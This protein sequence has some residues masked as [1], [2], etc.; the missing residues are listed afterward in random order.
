MQAEQTTERRKRSL[1]PVLV[2]LIVTGGV[3]VIVN[4]SFSGGVY[5][6]PL[7]DL[8]RDAPALVGKQVRVSGK[9]A[10]G[11][12]RGNV[13]DLDVTFAIEDG[14]GHTMAVHTRKILPD[15]FAE[16]RDVIVEGTLVQA[17][18]IEASTITVKCPSRYQDGE[19]TEEQA[20]AY[21]RQRRSQAAR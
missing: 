5:E 2:A 1:F 15:P 14:T 11:S 19:M 8:V 16:G 9:V 21:Y 7:G 18:R 20:R 17:D 4:S 10:P 3:V 13:D 6:Y 12:I